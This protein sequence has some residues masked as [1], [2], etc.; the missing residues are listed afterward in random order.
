MC[1]ELGEDSV[2]KRATRIFSG[3]D[4]GDLPT[5]S[6]GSHTRRSKLPSVRFRD[7][8]LVLS[9][10]LDFVGGSRMFWMTFT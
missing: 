5:A 2:L 3:W 7:D 10:A 6:C 8:L 1:S 9:L 4:L